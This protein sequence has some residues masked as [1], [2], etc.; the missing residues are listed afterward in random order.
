MEYKKIKRAFYNFL[1]KHNAYTSYKY[2][3][4]KAN[5]NSIDFWSRSRPEP[6]DFI[7]HA[8]EWRMTV[9]GYKFWYNLHVLWKA[10]CANLHY[11]K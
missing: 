6:N 8:F 1:Q 7:S 11:N 2:Y 5:V 9:E 4:H 3:R 10:V